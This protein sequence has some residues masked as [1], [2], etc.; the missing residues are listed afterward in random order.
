MDGDE[1]EIIFEEPETSA[2]FE[3]QT[4][5]ASWKFPYWLDMERGAPLPKRVVGH[6]SV[7]FEHNKAPTAFDMPPESNQPT[8]ILV[9]SKILNE[10]KYLSHTARH[11]VNCSGCNALRHTTANIY[12]FTFNGQDV[13]LSVPDHV[14]FEDL[15]AKLASDRTAASIVP[16]PL[17]DR[18]KLN[19]WIFT[20]VIPGRC[21]KGN[22]N[23]RH[24]MVDVTDVRAASVSYIH[25]L[26][27]S[28]N[29]FEECKK[30]WRSTHAIVKI[31]A[32]LYEIPN[33][34]QRKKFIQKFA[35][36]LGLR[37]IFLVDDNIPYVYSVSSNSLE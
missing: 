13:E 9:N 10:S 26:V 4:G 27:V 20:P 25:L 6:E 23:L 12:K 7:Q 15:R 32:D 37:R 5:V 35:E 30:T 1:E 2:D 21:Q 18:A 22:L 3:I 14:Y 28:A 33:D 36:A 17:S 16:F 31:P 19:T 24:T 11:S 29:D 34:G 8:R